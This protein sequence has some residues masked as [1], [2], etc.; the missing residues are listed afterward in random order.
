MAYVSNVESIKDSN[1]SGKARESSFSAIPDGG[2]EADLVEKVHH[3]SSRAL[4]WPSIF[5]PHDLVVISAFPSA[6]TR[7]GDATVP[8]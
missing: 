2:L 5:K 1:A 3:C 7:Y 6:E 8:F 4:I